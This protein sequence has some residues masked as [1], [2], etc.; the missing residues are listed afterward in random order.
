MAEEKASSVHGASARW[1]DGAVQDATVRI[2]G[3][4]KIRLIRSGIARL[5]SEGAAIILYHIAD[6]S[7]V[8]HKEEPKS[9]EIRDEHTDAVEFLIRSYPKFVSV[10]SL[11]CDS[12]EDKVSLAKLLFEQSLVHS[13]E[14][15]LPS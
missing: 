9:L 11:P 5:C 4:T 7:R 8:Y 2:K 14:P 10:A 6:N 1:E 15:L 12:F 13:S 3:N